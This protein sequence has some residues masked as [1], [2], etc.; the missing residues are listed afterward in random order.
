MNRKPGVRVVKFVDLH[1]VVG[2]INWLATVKQTYSF[3]GQYVIIYFESQHDAL[4]FKLM[5][6]GTTSGPPELDDY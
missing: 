5:F 6:G 3:R 1:D 4:A 2:M